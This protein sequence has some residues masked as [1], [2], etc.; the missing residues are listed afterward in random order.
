VSAVLEGACGGAAT[1]GAT[2]DGAGGATGVLA[3]AASATD[4][5]SPETRTVS[6]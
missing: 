4:A 1:G 2:G 5:S 3:H 6:R